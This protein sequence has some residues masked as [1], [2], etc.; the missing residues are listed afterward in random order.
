M[1]DNICYLA[2]W[3]KLSYRWFDRGLPSLYLLP[4]VVKYRFDLPNVF[5]SSAPP[6][7]FS[8]KAV[9]ITQTQRRKTAWSEPRTGFEEVGFFFFFSSL[10]QW[11]ENKRHYVSVYAREH[12]ATPSSTNYSMPNGTRWGSGPKRLSIGTSPVMDP[13]QGLLVTLSLRKP[14]PSRNRTHVKR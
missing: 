10:S 5:C 11:P 2:V 1:A 8:V 14:L 7:K 9:E 4:Q 3:Q 12:W 13:S 6:S